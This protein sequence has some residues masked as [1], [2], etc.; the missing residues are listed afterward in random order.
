M[1]P[2]FPYDEAT[3]SVYLKQWFEYKSPSYMFGNV[4]GNLVMLT[5]KGLIWTPFTNLNI[6]C[7]HPQWTNFFVMH[8]T[9]ITQTDDEH[10]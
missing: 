2:H 7:I 5:L 10:I 9:L 3:I 8:I 4:C 6:T 1:L